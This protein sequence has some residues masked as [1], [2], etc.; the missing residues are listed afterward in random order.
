MH[1]G[2]FFLTTSGL[3]SFCVGNSC[4]SNV[5]G[6]RQAPGDESDRAIVTP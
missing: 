5:R 3:C 2:P 1:A 6:M 4:L